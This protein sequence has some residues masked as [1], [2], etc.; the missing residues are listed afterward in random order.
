[1]SDKVPAW[2]KDLT[3]SPLVVAE[4]KS[5]PLARS[6][7]ERI[8]DARARGIARSKDS[9]AHPTY[10]FGH[11]ASYWQDFAGSETSGW[12]AAVLVCIANILESPILKRSKSVWQAKHYEV[13]TGQFNLSDTPPVSIQDLKDAI[14]NRIDELGLSLAAIWEWY[15]DIREPIGREWWR[16]DLET[17]IQKFKR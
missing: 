2:A 17:R 13:R 16:E 10:G 12:D 3:P 6:D 9:S 11:P 7:A 1:M 14:Q 8:A 15:A 4:T 5:I